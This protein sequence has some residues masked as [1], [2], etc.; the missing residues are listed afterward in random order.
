MKRSMKFLG[1][2]KHSWKESGSSTS[3]KNL[4]TNSSTVSGFPGRRNGLG[5]LTEHW[6]MNILSLASEAFYWSS[7]CFKQLAVIFKVTQ[8]PGTAP[9]E[10]VFSALPGPTSL[11]LYCCVGMDLSQAYP[12]SQKQQNENPNLSKTTPTRQ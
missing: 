4:R 8:V 6:E 3:L 5:N 11:G 9:G 12:L 7:G 10:Q 1:I 2:F